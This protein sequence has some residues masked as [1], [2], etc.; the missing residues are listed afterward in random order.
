MAGDTKRAGRAIDAIGGVAPG[1][2]A[3]NVLVCMPEQVD[4]IEVAAERVRLIDFFWG[5]P[6]SELVD[7]AHRG[8]AL[9]SW[10]VGSV[11]EARLAEDAGCD[12]IIAQGTEA[13]GHVGGQV[14]L[15][16]LVEDVLDRVSIPVLASGGIG[17]AR[18]LA[19]VLAAGAS[20]ARIGTRF[21]S[22]VETGAHPDYVK[23]LTEAESDDSVATGAFS[24]SCPLCPST[25]PAL[26]AR[27]RTDVHRRHRRPHR[28]SRHAAPR[29]TVL[30][31]PSNDDHDGT[32]PR[33]GPL[34]GARRW[35]LPA[36]SD[37]R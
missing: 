22:A 9:V 19:A 21:V 32:D 3:V 33:H 29:A 13:G 12:V 23:A 27:G 37:R 2:L 17:S 7:R 24:V 16:E 11:D 26:S 34:R 35:A 18:R 6:R 1:A 10:Q 30:I 8:G 25:G 15:F 31:H 20:G 36:W 4:L 5:D 14:P 28:G